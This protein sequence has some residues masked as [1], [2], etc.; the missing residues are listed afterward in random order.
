M[1][2]GGLIAGFEA[3]AVLLPSAA[4]QEA[5]RAAL[6]DP[7]V[8]AARLDEA[9]AG[10]PFR[11]DAFRPFLDA[12][13]ATRGMAPLRPADLA[14]TALAGRLDP[15]LY[16]RGGTWHGPVL[17]QGVREPARIAAALGDAGPGST[18]VDTRAELG[19]ILAGYTARAWRW[20][21]LGM[22]AI[23]LVLAA[24]LRDARRVARVAASVAAAVL[25]TVALLTALGERLSLVHVVA[26]QLVAGVGLDYALFFA[27]RQ[28]D[29]EERA[30]TLRT[31][32]TCNA[33]TLLSFG[34]LLFCRTPLLHSIG[35]TVAIGGAA[36][37]PSRSCSPGEERAEA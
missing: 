4:T 30:R 36:P 33:M 10:L 16:A 23:L 8:L 13:A 11:P 32:V 28:L 7:D 5:R 37:W 27:R 35:A 3:A 17:L 2:A 24:G 9:R 14:G 22:G 34:L 12:V 15:L 19:R 26:L 1:Q 21:A 31:L 20:L 6:P 29:E 18:Y 25:C